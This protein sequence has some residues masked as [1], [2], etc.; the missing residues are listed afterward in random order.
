MPHVASTTTPSAAAATIAAPRSAILRRH[1]LRT[2]R[3]TSWSVGRSALNT[4]SIASS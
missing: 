1:R 4:L 3:M 2:S